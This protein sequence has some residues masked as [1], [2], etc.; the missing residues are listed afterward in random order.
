[1][2]AVLWDEAA[3]RVHLA[4]GAHGWLSLPGR[5]ARLPVTVAAIENL[6]IMLVAPGTGYLSG[7][8]SQAAARLEVVGVTSELCRWVTRATGVVQRAVS[9]EVS[10]ARTD[11]FRDAD[12][13][14]LH[15]GD[16]SVLAFSAGCIR[17]FQSSRI[18]K[19]S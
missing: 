15:H 2:L 17:G 18:P 10:S 11:Q 6:D 19:D 3:C 1:M 14:S 4:P 9:S 13:D 8:P 16:F 5:R 7:V 12:A